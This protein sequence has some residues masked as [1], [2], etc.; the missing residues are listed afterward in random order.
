LAFSSA[1]AVSREHAGA[2]EHDPERPHPPRI[3]IASDDAVYVTDG[4]DRTRRFDLGGNFQLSWDDTAGTGLFGNPRGVLIDAKGDVIIAFGR[5]ASGDGEFEFPEG[6]AVTANGDV[7]AAD[8]GT[9][10]I[11]KTSPA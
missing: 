11:Q 4:S 3:G 1:P 8:S 2:A 5:R 10:R 6:V 7:F 9:H